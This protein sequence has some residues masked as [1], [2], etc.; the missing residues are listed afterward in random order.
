MNGREREGYRKVRRRG[1][2]ARERETGKREKGDPNK[3]GLI[4]KLVMTGS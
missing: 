4:E 3:I 2:E 1:R